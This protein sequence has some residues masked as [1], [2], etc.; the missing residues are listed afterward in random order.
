MGN[1]SSKEIDSSL[2]LQK[3]KEIN[4]SLEN[5]KLSNN[6]INKWSADIL[7]IIISYS[8]RSNQ[9]QLINIL[10]INLEKGKNELKQLLSKIN[11]SPMNDS[12]LISQ[13]NKKNC[14]LNNINDDTFYQLYFNNIKLNGKSQNIQYLKSDK[15]DIIYSFMFNLSYKIKDNMLSID[16]ATQS[17]NID[18]FVELFKKNYGSK[19]HHRFKDDQLYWRHDKKL[20]NIEYKISYK[21]CKFRRI[22]IDNNY[23][24][25]NNMSC[26]DKKY[27]II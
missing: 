3:L 2:Y 7:S 13:F 26:D 11:M 23:D 16:K 19:D 10:C 8:S 21:F 20:Q 15:N 24:I 17:F 18:K 6:I 25:I 4:Q 22:P 5:N 14:V 1:N 9:V 27:K 12:R